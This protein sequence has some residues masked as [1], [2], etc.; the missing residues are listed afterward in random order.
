MIAILRMSLQVVIFK[1][2][3]SYFHDSNFMANEGGLNVKPHK[4]MFSSIFFTK[5]VRYLV[6]DRGV[7]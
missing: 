1:E 7:E 4:E 3:T 5:G 6:L 2:V